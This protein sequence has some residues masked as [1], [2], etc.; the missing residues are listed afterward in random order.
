MKKVPPV[1][2]IYNRA[3]KNVLQKNTIFTEEIWHARLIGRKLAT[4]FTW[5]FLHTN[6][7]PNTVT[8]IAMIIGAT[9][10]LVIAVP[11]LTTLIIGV[12]MFELHLVLDSSDGELAR[13]KKKFSLLGNYLDTLGHMLIYSCLYSGL[14]INIY[15]RTNNLFFL[16]LGFLTAITYFLASSVHHLDPLREGKTYLE[17]R[18]GERKIVFLG[19][20]TYNVLTEDLNIVFALGIFG[21]FQYLGIIKVDIFAIILIM[22]SILLLSGGILFNLGRKIINSRYD[23]K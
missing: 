11:K 9:A 5:L 14:G 1:K 4:Y 23:K 8:I 20:N 13:F 16:I 19:I 12:F 15:L 18:K 21:T 6:I 2:E 7:T 3:S 22:N 10:C 17:Y